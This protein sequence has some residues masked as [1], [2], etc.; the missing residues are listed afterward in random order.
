MKATLAFATLIIVLAIGLDNGLD[1][2]VDKLQGKDSAP[3]VTTLNTEEPEQF[4]I[5]YYLYTK[6]K[7]VEFTPRT[8][9]DHR[10][11]ITNSFKG[12]GL[13]CTDKYGANK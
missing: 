4:V 6:F 13:Y 5:S 11:I 10:C 7:A 8:M 2:G 9:P 12:A 3:T 1:N